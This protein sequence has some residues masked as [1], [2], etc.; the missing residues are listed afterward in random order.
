MFIH[1]L[2]KIKKSSIN[3]N[4]IIYF[5]IFL[6]MVQTQTNSCQIQDLRW[7]THIFFTLN[8]A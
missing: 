1:S 2:R 7:H 5:R 6:T 8:Q 4:E 3:S